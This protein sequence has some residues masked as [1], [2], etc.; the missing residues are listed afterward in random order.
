MRWI[1]GAITPA[2]W[3]FEQREHL[4]EMYEMT[5][6]SHYRE[7]FRPGSVAKDIRARPCRTR[8][9]AGWRSSRPSWMSWKGC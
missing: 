4:L 8:S 3:G 7:H 6:G 5:S 2:L 9:S 1:A